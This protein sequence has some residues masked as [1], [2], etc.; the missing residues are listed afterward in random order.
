M[1]GIMTKTNGFGGWRA[2]AAAAVLATTGAMGGAAAA[3]DGAGDRW[4]GFSVAI[5]GGY[6]ESSDEFHVTARGRDIGGVDGIGGGG[7]T[8][9]LAIGYDHRIGDV[10]IGV[11]ADLGGI[12][13]G[14]EGSGSVMGAPVD[15]SLDYMLLAT[16]RVRAGYLVTEDT[17]VYVTG[18]VAGAQLQG[19]VSGGQ[20]GSFDDANTRAGWIIGAGAEH[21][22]DENISIRAEWLHADLGTFETPFRG[23]QVETSTSAT[24]ARVGVVWRF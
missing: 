8:G 24:I 4:T 9:S 21:A 7:L 18:G 5:S 22:I 19:K 17:L 6:A 23:A 10:V 12:E 16:A 20:F 2:A 14:G 13:A 15:A 11:E 1:A 3:E